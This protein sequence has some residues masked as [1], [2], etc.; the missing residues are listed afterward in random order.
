MSSAPKDGTMLIL[1]IRHG[2]TGEPVEVPGCWMMPG[3]NISLEGWWSAGAV[4]VDNSGLPQ[5]IAPTA[6]TPQRWRP[7]THRHYRSA[8]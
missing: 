5:K 3:G 1:T 4:H 2:W 8:T 6:I 7:L